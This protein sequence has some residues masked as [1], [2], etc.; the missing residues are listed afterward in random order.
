MN[1]YL[2]DVWIYTD[3]QKGKGSG[4][5]PGFA[6]ALVAESTAGNLISAEVREGEGRRG[7][8]GMR[9]CKVLQ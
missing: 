4:S 8:V 6:L 9:W 1:N 3:V 5:S 2:P 7:E